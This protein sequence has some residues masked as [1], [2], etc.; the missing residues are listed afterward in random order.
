MSTDNLA[1]KLPPEDN[2]SNVT[3]GRL[4]SEHAKALWKQAAPVATP[5]ASICGFCADVL[6]PLGPIVLYL[7]LF[8]GSV[9]VISGIIWYG[10]KRRQIIDALADGKI[11]SDEY[12]HFTLSS[13]WPTVFAFCFVSSLIM[14]VFF[15]AQKVFASDPPGTG[16]LASNFLAVEE[17][18]KRLLNIEQGNQRIEKSVEG[19]HAKL[20][21]LTEKL[22]QLDKESEIIEF[23]KGPEDH[24]LNA[25]MFEMRNDHA[26]ARQSLLE[27]MKS[28]LLYLDPHLSLTGILK[29]Q[30][31]RQ[32][33]HETYSMF[34]RNPNPSA[35][36]AR[37][38]LLDREARIKAL[39]Q[40][41]KD[42]PEYGPAH[43][44]LSKEFSAP[45]EGQQTLE[46]LKREREALESFRALS[47]RGLFSKYFIDKRIALSLESEGN[48]RL[49]KFATMSDAY[50]NAKAKMTFLPK[51]DGWEAII[52]LPYDGA[53]VFVKMPGDSEYVST[54]FGATRSPATGRPL[55]NTVVSLNHMKSKGVISL[56]YK[57][58]QGHEQGPFDT[59]FDP[60][61]EFVE[62]AKK[63]M[64][65]EPQE[66]AP[67]HRWKDKKMVTLVQILMFRK[68]I[69]KLAVG[70]DPEHIEQNLKLPPSPASFTVSDV[71]A[72]DPLISQDV[73]AAWKNV[74][75]KIDYADGTSSGPIMLE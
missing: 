46:N 3:V 21:S 74:Y 52:V 1:P 27:Y 69:A 36:L 67:V 68:A 43:Y 53:E 58:N 8:T 9:C 16:I 23:P 30:D 40:I 14:T 5:V 63:T 28:D 54:G 50:L 20:D 26:K 73:P 37:G 10:V 62:F 70:P 15:G 71:A 75:M 41:V 65:K 35:L 22:G 25:R 18:Q 44:Y 17:L 45:E 7:A 32:S 56:K 11:T 31:G 60:V 47:D 29:L 38:L 72:D 42:F 64:P 57:D 33:A 34:L 12:E 48:L 61:K 13:S 49:R 66:L 19:L 51:E 24:Y 55:P 59:E 4:A 39:E 6:A 2:F